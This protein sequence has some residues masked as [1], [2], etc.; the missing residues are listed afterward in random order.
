MPLIYHERFQAPG[1]A[2]GGSRSADRRHV[3]Q[4]DDFGRGTAPERRRI[5][6]TTVLSE[7]AAEIGPTPPEPGSETIDVGKKFWAESAIDGQVTHGLAFVISERRARSAFFNA[8][9]EC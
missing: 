4:A 7:P 1:R 2:R 3:D 6:E 9:L 8:V 5:V